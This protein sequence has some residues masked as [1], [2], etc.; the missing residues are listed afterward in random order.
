MV[1]SLAVKRKRMRFTKPSDFN[2]KISKTVDILR[3]I[4]VCV[5][6]LAAV[7][8]YPIAYR[9]SAE[10]MTVTVSDKE[11]TTSVSGES[12][13]SRYLIFS[14][15]GEVFEN[16]DSVLYLKFDSS[17][18]QGHLKRG[19]KYEVKVAGWRIPFLSSHRNIIRVVSDIQ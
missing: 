9:S 3:V 1:R 12:T 11:R 15:E 17:D 2:K 13:I 19:Q 8:S 7:F 5:L 14:E 16:T 18:V 10:T 4:G 6:L